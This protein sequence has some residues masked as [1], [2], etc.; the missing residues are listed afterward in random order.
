MHS[1]M[2]L[3][4]AQVKWV[5]IEPSLQLYASHSDFVLSCSNRLREVYTSLMIPY[6]ETI[7]GERNKKERKKEREKE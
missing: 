1:E 4:C 5:T 6:E 2:P 3:L 7:F